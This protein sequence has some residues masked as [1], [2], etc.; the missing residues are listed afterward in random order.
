M[1]HERTVPYDFGDCGIFYLLVPFIPT[2]R[3]IFAFPAKSYLWQPPSYG[4]PAVHPLP[5]VH[6]AFILVFCPWHPCL[7]QGLPPQPQWIWGICPFYHC[8][9]HKPFGIVLFPSPNS[10]ANQKARWWMKYE[11]N[12]RH[13]QKWDSWN[14]ALIRNNLKYNKQKGMRNKMTNIMIFFQTVRILW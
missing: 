11:K 8:N 12:H 14:Y 3:W 2:C 10:E 6:D 7:E 4:F 13:I 5:K 9:M 1:D